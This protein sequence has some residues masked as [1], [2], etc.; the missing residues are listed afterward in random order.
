MTSDDIDKRTRNQCDVAN[1]LAVWL[2]AQTGAT[3]P[4]TADVYTAW[5]LLTHLIIRAEA[6]ERALASLVSGVEDIQHAWPKLEDLPPGS[7][8]NDMIGF[9]FA[10]LPIAQKA[11]R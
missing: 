9:L 11:L 8:L 7:P 5:T 1:A 6:L 2:N 10:T 4:H 3:T